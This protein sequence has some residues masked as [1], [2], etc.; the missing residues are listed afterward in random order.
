[1]PYRRE[2][3]PTPMFLPGEFREG[4]WPTIHGVTESQRQMSD[5]HTHTHTHTHVLPCAPKSGADLYA[6]D[7]NFR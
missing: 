7:S 3:Q 1:M 2:Q 6:I 4:W 5:S